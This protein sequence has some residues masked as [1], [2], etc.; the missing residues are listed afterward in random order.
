MIRYLVDSHGTIFKCSIATEGISSNAL[1][2]PNMAGDREIKAINKRAF[3]ETQAKQNIVAIHIPTNLFVASMAFSYFTNLVRLEIKSGSELGYRAIQNCDNLETLVLFNHTTLA[4]N[5]LYQCPKLRNIILVLNVGTQP[6][7]GMTTLNP[8]AFDKPL[9]EYYFTYTV[10]INII[11][12]IMA[13]GPAGSASICDHPPYNLT[14]PLLTTTLNRFLSDCLLRVLSPEIPITRVTFRITEEHPST[15][16]GSALYCKL[17]PQTQS[18]VLTFLLCYAR[19]V[20]KHPYL[21][22]ALPDH[23][24][25]NIFGVV[26]HTERDYMIKSIRSEALAPDLFKANPTLACLRSDSKTLNYQTIGLWE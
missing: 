16:I 19:F 8:S 23:I 15:Y 12:S 11:N 2:I 21:P 24:L 26:T 10:P 18:R 1:H 6:F 13:K 22:I 9:S 3:S 14:T 5:A 20:K 17:N 25:A 7:L 4:H